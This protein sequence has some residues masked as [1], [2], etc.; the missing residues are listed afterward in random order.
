MP[1]THKKVIVRRFSG[2]LL[3]GYLPASGFLDA[4]C[5]DLLGLDGR[6]LR[7]PIDEVRSISF[8][9]DFTLGDIAAPEP[10]PRKAFSGRPRGDGLWLRLTFRQDGDDLEG[11]AAADLALVDDLLRDGG[12]ALT[13]PDTR[14]NTQRIFVPRAAIADLKLL[15]VI[16]STRK[17]K[18]T[19]EVATAQADDPRRTTSQ[20]T[21]FQGADPSQAVRP[22]HTTKTPTDAPPAVEDHASS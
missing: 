15:G 14:G 19:E 2:D 16:T 7:I 1:S 12:L 6:R 18:Q 13:P 8:V 3:H 11:L 20:G 4:A 17:R 22:T 9:R 10:S 21:L 5:V